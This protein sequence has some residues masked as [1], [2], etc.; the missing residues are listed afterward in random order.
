MLKKISIQY[1]QL[2]ERIQYYLG[3]S[4][5]QTNIILWAFIIVLLTCIII[6][7]IHKFLK[8]SRIKKEKE[9]VK[10]VDE[11]IYLLAKAQHEMNID[12]RKL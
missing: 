10:S 5:L 4:T 8:K 3:T 11:M 1:Q 9:I 12:I 6:I 7:P 2:I